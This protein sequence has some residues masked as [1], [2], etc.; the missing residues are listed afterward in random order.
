M[1]IHLSQYALK[2]LNRLRST[3]QANNSAV[4]EEAI[5]RLY[6]TFVA[7]GVIQEG[8]APKPLAEILDRADLLKSLYQCSRN[9]LDAD[10][11]QNRP[12]ILEGNTEEEAWQKMAILFPEEVTYGFS[13]QE[14]KPID[15]NAL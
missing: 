9:A 8:E 2:L 5:I 12:L 14:I 13:I 4:V 1:E 3:L 11:P 10:H 6:R 15:F 7:D